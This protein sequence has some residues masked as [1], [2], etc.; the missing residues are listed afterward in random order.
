MNKKAKR[1][2]LISLALLCTT[3]I[4]SGSMLSMNHSRKYSYPLMDRRQ[5]KRS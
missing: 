1:S 3:L 5:W 2:L 4:M